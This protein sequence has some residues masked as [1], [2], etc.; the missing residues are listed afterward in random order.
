MT[1]A[2]PASGNVVRLLDVR[3]A[4]L[5]VA[6]VLA[7]VADPA[8]GGVNLFV[9]AVRDRDHDRDVLRLEYSAH[10]TALE[11]LAAVAAEVAAEFDLI[12]LAAVHRV[13]ALEIGDL[14]VVSAVS[15]AHRGQAF[16]ASRALIDRLK[17]RVPI[18]KHQAFADGTDEWVGVC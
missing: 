7:A 8:A 13:G 5:D 17:E 12:A 14:A 18:W 16:E 1:S 2:S 11:Q 3:D 4:P 9:G 10:P 6:E 15:A